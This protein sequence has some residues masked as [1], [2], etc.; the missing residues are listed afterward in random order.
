MEHELGLTALFNNYLP[1]V[2]TAILGVFS[3]K[4]NNPLRPWEDSVVMELL[5]VALLMITAAIVRANLSVDK[6]GKLQHFF[7]LL[8][9]FFDDTLQQVG[10]H[11]PEKYLPYIGTLFIFILSMNL[12]GAIPAFEAPTMAPW[13]PAGLAIVTFLYFNIMGFRA[14]GLHY[15]GHFAGPVRFPNPIA[16]IAIILFM[17]P[18]ETISIFIRPLSLTVRLYGNMFAGEQVTNVF[19][20]L[21]YLIIPVIFMAL[22]IFVALVQA[23]VFMLLTVIYVAGATTHEEEPAQAHA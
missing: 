14:Q 19:L 15:F 6:P 2:G 16:N 9:E 4:A 23:Y 11:H 20:G 13:V 3:L 10:V 5:V 1:G 18:I 8:Y 17:L 7:E 22:H 21:T 12:I